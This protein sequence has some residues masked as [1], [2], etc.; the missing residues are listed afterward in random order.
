MGGYNAFASTQIRIIVALF[1]FILVLTALRRWKS[2][3]MVFANRRA[4]R[5]IVVGSLF[6]PFLGVYFS[7]LVVQ[8]VSTGIAS[9]LMSIVPVLIIAPAVII[10]KERVTLTEITGVLLSV[11]GVALFF[12]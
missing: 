5:S 8:N 6:G 2:V 12:V 10:Y 4:M 3:A 11:I 1:G 9:T 7:L